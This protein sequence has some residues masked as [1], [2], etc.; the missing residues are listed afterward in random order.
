MTP[1]VI[2]ALALRCRA[3]SLPPARAAYA[4]SAIAYAAGYDVSRQAALGVTGRWESGWAVRYERCLAV[5]KGGWGTFGVASLW[6]EAY[7]GGTCGPIGQQARA[8][9]AILWRECRFL[10]DEPARGFACYLGVPRNPHY[11]VARERAAEYWSLME[12]I[13]RSACF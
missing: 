8:A 3:P 13:R 9:D 7:P 2:L 4:A 5:E 11:W 1:D 6:D 12:S 10:A